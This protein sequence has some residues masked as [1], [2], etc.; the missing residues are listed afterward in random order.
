MNQ[1]WRFPFAECALEIGKNVGRM[2]P[3]CRQTEAGA[4]KSL[5]LN[6]N[7]AIVREIGKSLAIHEIYSFEI[8]L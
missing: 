5:K 1:R 3:K 6:A 8:E 4:Q 2:W 7:P